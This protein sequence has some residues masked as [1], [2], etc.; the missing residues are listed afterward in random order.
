[1]FLQRIGSF[2]LALWA[3]FLRLFSPRS[4]PNQTETTKEVAMSEKKDFY[5]VE[6]LK[7]KLLDRDFQLMIHNWVQKTLRPLEND[8]EYERLC[9]MEEFVPTPEIMTAIYAALRP[10]HGGGVGHEFGGGHSWRDFLDGLAIIAHDPTL[11]TAY[12]NDVF[13]GLL[14]DFMHDFGNVAKPRYEDNLWEEGHAEVGAWQ[15]YQ[16]LQDLLPEH[17]LLLMAYA[18]AAH[19]HK[20]GPVTCDNGY[21]REVWN[22][23]MFYNMGHPVRV[24]VWLTRFADRLDTNGVTLFARHIPANIE[25]SFYGGKDFSAAAFYELDGKALAVMVKPTV[26][27]DGNAP[28]TLMHIGNF[29]N[30]S[31]KFG[32]YSQHDARFPSM[33]R[34][35]AY[36]A[37][38]GLRLVEVVNQ[39]IGEAQ[40][41]ATLSTLDLFWN[42]LCRV[43]CFES[44]E[45]TR[46]I[47]LHIWG[48]LTPEEQERWR[49]GLEFANEAYDQWL[50]LLYVE[51]ESS[52]HPMVVACKHL[53]P[54]LKTNLGVE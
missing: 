39:S 45:E 52:D 3:S 5:T 24:A 4:T 14:G 50:R 26:V 40:P 34:L 29:A 20:L 10:Y 13:A 8:A 7:V 44:I 36:K 31:F 30:S 35:M 53:L 16:V 28:S 19:T 9:A 2:L 6:E 25:G 18:I 1:M 37:N 21:V 54:E 33:E 32:A 46:P 38:Q 47:F 51:I 27:K 43:S 41:Q 23:R 42:F 12:P 11:K 48:E 49:I 17:I 22:D 15:A